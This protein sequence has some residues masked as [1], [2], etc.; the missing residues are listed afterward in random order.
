MEGLKDVINNALYENFTKEIHSFEKDIKKFVDK[1]PEKSYLLEAIQGKEKDP[2]VERLFSGVAF[3]VS[4]LR[5]ELDETLDSISEAIL[6][7]H[8]P[9]V[10]Q[11][12]PAIMIVEALSIKAPSGII[13]SQGEPLIKTAPIGEEKTECIFSSISDEKFSKISKDIYLKVI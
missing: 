1:Y 12:Y 13:V 11:P 10:F 7:Q 8:W 3:L 2:Y 6:R 9:F 5:S 4:R